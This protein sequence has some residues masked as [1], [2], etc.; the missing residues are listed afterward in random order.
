MQGKEKKV[1][2]AVFSKEI[3]DIH[4]TRRNFETFIEVHGKL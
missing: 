3:G 4:D 2:L 1:V